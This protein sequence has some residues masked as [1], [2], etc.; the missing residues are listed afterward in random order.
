MD[1][2]ETLDSKADE[3]AQKLQEASSKDRLNI[4]R[5]AWNQ[6]RGDLELQYSEIRQMP[7]EDRQNICQLIAENF[8][9]G[10]N[11]HYKITF[12]KRGSVVVALSG[13]NGRHSNLTPAYAL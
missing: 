11:Y 10:Q 1:N 12:E 9:F 6:I 3:L 7:E 13:K 5:N 2:Y 4:K 8:V